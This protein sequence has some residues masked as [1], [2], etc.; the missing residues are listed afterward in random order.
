MLDVQ[1]LQR[2]DPVIFVLDA[3]H[4]WIDKHVT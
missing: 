3:P 1:K 4:A 2:G